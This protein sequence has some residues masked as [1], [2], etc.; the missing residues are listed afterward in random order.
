MEASYT[1][2]R[3]HFSGDT[4]PLQAKSTHVGKYLLLAIGIIT[5][6]GSIIATGCLYSR[7]GYSSFAIGGTGL[8]LGVFCFR[9]STLCSKDTTSNHANLKHSP[10]EN[11]PSSHHA[12]TNHRTEHNRHTDANS[13]AYRRASENTTSNHVSLKH[14]Q[15]AN[16]NQRAEH[17][18]ADT[19]SIRN[20]LPCRHEGSS[21]FVNSALQIMAHLTDFRNLF[22]KKLHKLEKGTEE[23]EACLSKRQRVQEVGNELISCILE[24]R[25]AQGLGK[26]IDTVNSALEA[27]KD[28][29]KF[30]IQSGGDS[31]LL[32]DRV[33]KILIP[34]GIIFGFSASYLN[35]LDQINE[36]LALEESPPSTLVFD[37]QDSCP[38]RSELA[39]N[40][41]GT[42]RL[43]AL[44][45]SI[46]N[47]AVPILCS[48]SGQYFKLDDVVGRAEEISEGELTNILTNNKNSPRAYYLKVN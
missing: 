46:G 22:D 26:F 2:G 24:G 36:E 13:I 41:M 38:Y 10:V 28:Y 25:Q 4:T 12:N 48:Q 31:N 27:M 17:L 15:P 20:R 5:L 37:N 1:S 18:H 14:S 6:A 11:E 3:S 32:I 8:V 40:A 16:T 43:A 7:L 29:K 33:E 9:S 42:Y 44:R 19:N 30:D 21:C 39:L 34:G 45:I 47:H 35:Q 23:E